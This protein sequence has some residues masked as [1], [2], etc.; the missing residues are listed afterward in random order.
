M[1]A[2]SNESTKQRWQRANDKQEAKRRAKEEERARAE[3]LVEA[4]ARGNWRAARRCLEE[5]ARVGNEEHMG[6]WNALMWASRH[7][8]AACVTLML[9]AGARV[10]AV[11][12]ADGFTPLL[13]AAT[14]GNHQSMKVC[15]ASPF[16]FVL[17]LAEWR[18]FWWRP[19]RM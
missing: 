17:V 1:R 8:G 2:A 10:N 3:R 12:G 7:G 16:F 9:S 19:R 5:G 15:S 18:S 6:K 11:C 13:C 4:C 14:A